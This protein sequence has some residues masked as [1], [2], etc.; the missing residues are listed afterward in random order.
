MSTISWLDPIDP[1][2]VDPDVVA[3]AEAHPMRRVTHAAAAEVGVWEGPLIG[4]V[5][6][7]FD[8]LAGEWH[9]KHTPGALDALVDAL[10]R[11]GLPDHGLWL[12]L[13]A[14][15]GWA[16]ATL[17]ARAPALLAVELSSRMLAASPAD[18]VARLQ[19]D[20]NRLPV[21]DHA[22]TGAVL[23][24]M[25]LFPSELDR[26]LAPGGSLLWLSSRGPATPIHLTPEQVAAAMP[27]RWGG[28]AARHG[29]AV[30]AVLERRG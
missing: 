7:T 29:T 20:A 28:V 27:G 18:G 30:W 22:A 5:Q 14:G 25:L 21:D 2:D 26:V 6:A 15:D 19:A 3:A 11:G 13:G 12:E 1:Q 16:S 10:D 9:T 17:A 23:M 24:N 8:D 4:Q